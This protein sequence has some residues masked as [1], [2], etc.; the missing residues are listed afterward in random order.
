MKRRASA[1]PGQA[2]TETPFTAGTVL[3]CRKRVSPR[4]LESSRKAL[5]ERGVG[6][7]GRQ[8][9]DSRQA[10]QRRP[11]HLTGAHRPGEVV[12]QNEPRACDSLK[13]T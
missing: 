12:E 3:A 10:G 4:T 13:E 5:W 2:R 6:G 1:P 8:R 7:G 11:A 9:R